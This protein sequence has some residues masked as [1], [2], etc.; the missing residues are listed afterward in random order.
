M[1]KLYVTIPM[2]TKL[3]TLV[4]AAVYGVSRISEP[5]F[6]AINFAAVK[7][8]RKLNRSAI[9]EIEV[10]SKS[11]SQFKCVGEERTTLGD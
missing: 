4:C 1:P 11:S 5:E 2:D 8:G 10:D 6:K 3:L 9:K 7:K